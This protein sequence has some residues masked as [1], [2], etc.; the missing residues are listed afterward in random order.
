[1]NI[2]L[3]EEEKNRIDGLC[4]KEKTNQEIA[5]KIGRS[6]NTIKSYKEKRLR[7]LLSEKYGAAE[8]DL[9]QN[10]TLSQTTISLALDKLQ[11][12]GIK[13]EDA[14]KA[15]KKAEDLLQEPTEDPNRV[16]ALC[17]QYL[18]IHNAMIKESVGE[19]Q[20]V[21]VLTKSAS[22]IL[23]EKRKKNSNTPVTKNLT[24]HIFSPKNG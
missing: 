7:E 17:M 23:D 20:K 16:A 8:E 21:T 4:I 2:R 5:K 9:Q 12:N 13:K 6:L 14:E 10:I 15:I 18:N 24:S 22:E 11:K 3:T 19:K 1:M